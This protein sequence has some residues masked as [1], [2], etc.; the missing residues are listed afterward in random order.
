MGVCVSKPSST[1]V[2]AV[3]PIQGAPPPSEPP[4]PQ[5]TAEIEAMRRGRERKFI[6]SWKLLRSRPTSPFSVPVP[7]TTS[8][9]KSLLW[10]LRQM[11][12]P[13][14]RPSGSLGSHFRRR[15]LLN[16]SWLYWRDGTAQWS[17]MRHRF[18]RGMILKDLVWTRVLDSPS[19]LGTSMSLEKRLGR[20]ILA[21]CRATVKK[22]ELK[23][24]QVAVKVI[25]K[26]KVCYLFPL[27][28]PNFWS[29]LCIIILPFMF[30]GR[31][32]DHLLIL[33]FRRL[34]WCDLEKSLRYPS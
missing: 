20:G 14:P 17:R 34:C 21:T 22:G 11:W 9:P 1:T 19:I 2:V 18:L 5:S 26:A 16:I 32:V 3:P 10:D 27:F 28:Q 29:S 8:S 15:P 7:L 12:A 4:P 31:R 6:S 13:I 25:P 24:K 33:I 23:G 30:T